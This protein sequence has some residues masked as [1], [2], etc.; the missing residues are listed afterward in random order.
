LTLTRD[1]VIKRS[2]FEP[3]R[4]CRVVYENFTW[5]FEPAGTPKARVPAYRVF[6]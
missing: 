1:A 2:S 3:A 4:R 5:A 6:R